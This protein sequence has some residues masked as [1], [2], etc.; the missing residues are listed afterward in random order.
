M[1]LQT[2]EA[3]NGNYIMAAPAVINVGSV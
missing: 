1:T 3:I 2:G